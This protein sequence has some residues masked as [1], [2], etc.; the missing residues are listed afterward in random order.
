MATP[1][2]R[3]LGYHTPEQ[4]SNPEPPDSRPVLA[5]PISSWLLFIVILIPQQLNREA[6][7][8]RLLARPTSQLQVRKWTS[9]AVESSSIQYLPRPLA[10]AAS[11]LPATRAWLQCGWHEAANRMPDAMVLFEEITK[12][13]SVTAKY[14]TIGWTSQNPRREVHGFGRRSA[15]GDEGSRGVSLICKLVLYN[16]VYNIVKYEKYG[17]IW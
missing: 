6:V 17:E 15:S 2:G 4:V 8:A 5:L 13:D 9:K 12:G 10:I 3:R 1:Q 14:K 7:S 11:V 16:K